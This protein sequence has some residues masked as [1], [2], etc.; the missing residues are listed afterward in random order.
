MWHKLHTF[1]TL[2]FS[3][4]IEK[5]KAERASNRMGTHPGGGSVQ[6]NKTLGRIDIIMYVCNDVYIH[7]IIDIE[8]YRHYNTGLHIE[9]YRHYIYIYTTCVYNVGIAMS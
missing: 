9:H 6:R 1:R 4:W 8:H 7:N 5:P 3:A 2:E